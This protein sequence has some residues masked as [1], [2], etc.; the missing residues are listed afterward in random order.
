MELGAASRYGVLY[1]VVWLSQL[2]QVDEQLP[3]ICYIHID[4]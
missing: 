4:V 3:I 2:D 1:F